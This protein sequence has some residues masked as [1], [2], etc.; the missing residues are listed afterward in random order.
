MPPLT[1]IIIGVVICVLIYLLY[2]FL[3][4][5]SG[6]S[7]LSYL[8]PG[9]E[10][11]TIPSSS[12]SKDSG[13]SNWSYSIWFAVDDWNYRIDEPKIIFT[14]MDTKGNVGPE[15]SL[16]SIQ[17]SINVA[18]ST[19]LGTK[20]TCTL[21]NVP[22]QKWTNL[23]VALNNRALDLYLDGKLVRTCILDGV[24][25]LSSSAS[26]Y[27]TPGGG[28]SGST[29]NFR[30][31]SY[32]LNPRQAYEIYRE[33]YGGSGLGNFFNKYRIKLAFMEDGS[34]VGSLEI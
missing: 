6:A 13:T 29:S 24:P 17:N 28:F 14:R 22:L 9:N 12:L 5:S 25:K 31:F 30:Q 16:G 7:T 19:Y 3:T 21:N 20:K 15:V 18:V 32:A 26:L 2:L 11:D 10:E 1:N 23:I 33:G 8:H 34:E 4:R 27:L